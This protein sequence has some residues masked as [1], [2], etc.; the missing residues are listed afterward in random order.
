[1]PTAWID[2]YTATIGALF[3]VTAIVTIVFNLTKKNARIAE[4]E[5]DA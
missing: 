4:A 3:V 2:Q 5:L 1:M